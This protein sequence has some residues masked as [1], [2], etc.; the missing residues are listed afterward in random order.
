LR[1]LVEESWVQVGIHG[2]T[3]EETEREASLLTFDLGDA[4]LDAVDATLAVQPDLERHRLLKG[5]HKSQSSFSV[6]V[7]HQGRRKW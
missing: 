5:K 6:S 1:N 3:T 7:M 4:A 2:R